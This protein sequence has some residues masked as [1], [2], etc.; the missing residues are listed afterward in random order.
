MVGE[1]MEAMKSEI[2]A[3]WVGLNLPYHMR[4]MEIFPGLCGIGTLIVGHFVLVF[5]LLSSNG[6][7]K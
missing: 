7:K 6:V 2:M 1:E 3:R 5:L 4:L